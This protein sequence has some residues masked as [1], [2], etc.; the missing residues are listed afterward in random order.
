MPHIHVPVGATGALRCAAGPDRACQ[1]CQRVAPAS[2][3]ESVVVVGDLTV[4]VCRDTAL[5]A[6][7]VHR[8]YHSPATPNRDCAHC[9][10]GRPVTRTAAVIA[11]LGLGLALAL[12]GCASRASQSQPPATA[13]CHSANLDA[14]ACHGDV[15]VP[16]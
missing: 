5:C 14:G 7:R 6:E 2:E 15:Y 1:A 3:I 8:L 12:T 16:S 11:A 4:T 10:A 9:A 13:T